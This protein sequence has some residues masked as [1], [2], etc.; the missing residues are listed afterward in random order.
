MER[1]TKPAKLLGASLVLAAIL[2][3]GLASGIGLNW[4]FRIDGTQDLNVAYAVLAVWL[5]I[6]FGLA[7]AVLLDAARLARRGDLETL[8]DSANFVKVVAIPFFVFNF[9]ALTE[10][11][12]VT[13]ANDELRLGLSG[14]LAALL[15]VALTYVVFLPTSAYGVACLAVMRK[16]D[17]IG[18]IFYGIN[19][20]LHFLFVVDVFSSIVMVEVARDRIGTR[21]PPG[22]LL[23]NLMAGVLTVCSAFALVWLVCLAL[24]FWLHVDAS[25]LSY[26]LYYLGFATPLAF[27]ALALVPVVPLITFRTAVRLFLGDDLDGL[28]QSARTVKLSLIP[29]FLQ[30]F[31]LGATIVLVWTLLPVAITRGAL[32]FMGPWGVAFVGAT[33]ASALIPA[34]VGTYLMMLPTSIYGVT[35]LVLMLRRHVISPRFC[36]LH[37]VLQFIFVADIIST[38]V[39]A[40]RARKVLT[41]TTPVLASV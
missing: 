28:R 23:T 27:L 20:V 33:A 35:C 25:L 6:Y 14:F 31:V 10:A 22:P 39:V 38:L 34:V 11:V 3:A 26:V 21:R 18:P 40:H 13:G 37:I 2:V 7:I 41:A 4:P 29:L 12:T 19:L 36:A 16:N 8:Q 5:L 30:N 9:I 17:Q 32:L 24:V 15:F 1:V